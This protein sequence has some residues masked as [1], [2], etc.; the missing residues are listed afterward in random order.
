MPCGVTLSLPIDEKFL[1]FWK[2]SAHPRAE[3]ALPDPGAPSR[4]R[5]E[6]RTPVQRDSPAV[7]FLPSL[8]FSRMVAGFLGIRGCGE[9]NWGSLVSIYLRAE[10]MLA[11]WSRKTRGGVVAVTAAFPS[12]FGEQRELT[13]MAHRAVTDVVCSSGNLTAGATTPVSG[14]RAVI[15]LEFNVPGRQDRDCARGRRQVC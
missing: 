8:C 4:P 10:R 15:G 11:S 14:G 5:A 6:D 7:L 13:H 1:W 3:T 9:R 2:H 12:R